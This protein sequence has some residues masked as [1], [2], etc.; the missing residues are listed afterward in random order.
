M[1]RREKVAGLRMYTLAFAS[2]QVVYAGGLEVACEAFVS[3]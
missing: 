2:P 1:I 3:A